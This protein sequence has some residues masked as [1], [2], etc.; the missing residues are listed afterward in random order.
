MSISLLLTSPT[1]LDEQL[2][3]R[4]I[5]MSGIAVGNW[6]LQS[7]PQKKAETYLRALDCSAEQRS[8]CLK[9]LSSAQLLAKSGYE[10]KPSKDGSLLTKSP[11]IALKEGI[12]NKQV[13]EILLG[14]TDAEGYLCYLTHWAM[15]SK[16][17]Q[18]LAANE[19]T[20]KDFTSMAKADLNMIIGSNWTHDQFYHNLILS[21]LNKEQ[22]SLRHRY[23]DF[24]SHLLIHIPMR[25][26]TKLLSTNSK[27]TAYTYRLKYRPTYSILPKFITASG[28]G[29]DVLLLFA[30]SNSSF[31]FASKDDSVAKTMV[32]SFS[33]FATEGTPNARLNHVSAFNEIN[34]VHNQR[35]A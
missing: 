14:S 26:F 3:N 23:I 7:N 5:L 29:D 22:L 24:C 25:K 12:F 2:F 31:K 30:H 33:N 27:V 21:S 13:S 15:K 6:V 11:L 20:E 9:N 1:L 28:H 19:L 4:A 17:Y 8:D 34:T 10:W 18:K 35:R 16:Y 32:K